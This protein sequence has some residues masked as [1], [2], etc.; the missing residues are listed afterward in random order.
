MAP[1]LLEVYGAF[2]ARESLQDSALEKMQ[3][4][5]PN[6]DLQVFI[7]GINY[8]DN[9]NHESGMPNFLK[10]SDTYTAFA[11]LIQTT[12]GLDLDAEIDK[13]ITDLDAVF[14]EQE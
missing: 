11:S 6:A 1:Q 14:K 2:P 4:N 9:P 10:S 13:L 8:P 3:T 5:F 7:D 12:P